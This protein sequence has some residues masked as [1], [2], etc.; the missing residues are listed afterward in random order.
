MST[1]L[2]SPVFI[3][4]FSALKD[5]QG[6]AAILRR[7]VR[8][9]NG[10]LGDVKPVGGGILEMRVDVGPGYRVYCVRRGDDLIVLLCGGDKSSQG[11][12]IALAQT[13]AKEV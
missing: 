2:Q 7:L 8:A 6:R 12:D 5:V 1:I 9:G 3:H 10:H 11:R 4:G 13:M